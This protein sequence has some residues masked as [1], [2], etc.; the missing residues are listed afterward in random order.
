MLWFWITLGL[1]VVAAILLLT[2]L[3][4]VKKNKKRQTIYTVKE[5]FPEYNYTLPVQNEYVYNPL[6]DPK[7][8]EYKKAMLD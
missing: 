1:T 7:I 4:I 5:F 3:K 6:D 2:N 8:E